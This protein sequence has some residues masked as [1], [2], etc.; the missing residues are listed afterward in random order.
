MS[1]YGEGQYAS[2]I[3]YQTDGLRQDAE[4]SKRERERHYADPL[5]TRPEDEQ[6]HWS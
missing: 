3:F 1:E 5:Q 6:V 4:E 2:A